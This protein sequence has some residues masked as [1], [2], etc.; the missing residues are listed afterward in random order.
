MALDVYLVRPETNN[1]GGHNVVTFSFALLV[2]TSGES[3]R[4]GSMMETFLK[5]QQK[6]E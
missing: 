2:G 1:G 5:K 6:T 3:L 4:D